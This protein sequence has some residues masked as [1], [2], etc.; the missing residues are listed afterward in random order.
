MVATKN[1]DHEPVARKTAC[2]LSK[3]ASDSFDIP[4]HV[5]NEDMGSRELLVISFWGKNRFWS[6]RSFD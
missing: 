3:I 2:N 4:G 6:P 1:R 5:I